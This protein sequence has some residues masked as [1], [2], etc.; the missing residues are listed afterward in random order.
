[1]PRRQTENLEKDIVVM[2]A[3]SISLQGQSQGCSKLSLWIG[4]FP[5]LLALQPPRET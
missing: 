4:S 2:A 1:M 5:V 3:C